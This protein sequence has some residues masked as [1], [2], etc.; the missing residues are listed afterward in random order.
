MFLNCHSY[1][2]LRYGTLSIEKLVE[3]AKAC[4]IGT[5]ALTDINNSTGI[6]DFVKSC[7]E[8]G[9]K[10]VAGIE[11]RNGDELLYIGLAKNNAGFRELNDF[12]SHHT[13]RNLPLPELAP[14]FGN[15]V[16]IYP[17][18]NSEIAKWRNGEIK[19]AKREKRSSEN[20]STRQFTSSPVHQFFG[21]SPSMLR[22]LATINNASLLENAVILF[23]VTH[24]DE[25]EYDLHC[26][27]RAV[28]HNI[29]LSRLRPEQVAGP[30]E[31]MV[32][33]EKVKEIYK[34]YPQLIKNT[35]KLLGECSIGF[36]FSSC[37][38]KKTFTG[39]PY[40][41]RILLEKLAYDGLEYRYGKSDR[42][43][44]KR[45]RHELGIIDKMGFSSY[46]LITWD[47]IR[48]SMS[49]G[50]YHVGRGSGANS[51][52]AYCLRI[53]DVDPIE[54]DLYFE[55]FINPK[56][57][58]PPDFDIDYSWKERDEVLD[59][60]FK[61]YGH[62]HTALLGAMSTFKGN[63]IYRELGKVHGLPKGEMDDFLKYPE[64]ENHRNGIIKKISD[65]GA[66]LVDFPNIRSIHAGGV[67]ISDEPI[68]CYTALDM[69]P[70]GFPTTQWD[71]YV[72]E[73]IGFEKL[74]ILSQ[75]GIGHIRETAE[76][77]LKNRSE[78]VD[79]HRVQ[80]FK[81][82]EN[83][84][85][86]LRTGETIGCFY[87]ESPAMRGLLK[88]LRCDNY[89]S[90]VAASSIIRPGVA[91]S[92][93][94]REYI[95]RFH[96]P[97][98]FKYL[99]PIMEEQLKETYGVM[100]YQEDV[101]KICHH[102]AGLDLA[103]SDVLRRAMSGKFRSKKE[104]ERIVNKFFENCKSY[105]YPDEVTKEVW[106]QI[107]SFAGY[108]FSK[109][110]SASYAVES[111]QSLFLKSHYPLEFM[112]GVINNFGGFY[113]SWVY[114]NEARNC[115]AVL[116]LPCVNRGDYKTSISGKDVFVGFIHVANLENP[117]GKM[118][119]AERKAHG[120]Y[121]S[122]DDFVLRTHITLEQ[123]IILI[124]IG[125]FRFTGKT[126]A[127]LLWEAH[128]L[129]GKNAELSKSAFRPPTSD[130]AHHP[131]PIENSIVNRKSEIVNSPVNPVLFYTPPKEYTLPSL[132]QSSVEDVYDEVELLGFPV[133]H[134]YFDL[135][136]TSFRGEIMA[137]AMMDRM[138]K[139][140]RMLGQ[141]VTI[142]YVRTVKKEWMH[143]GTFTD[144]TGHFF[145]TVHFPDS[146]RKYPF[147]GDG[148]YLVL[149]KIVE[150]FGFPS[151]E[152]HKMAKMPMRKDPRAG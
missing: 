106:R 61:R 127:Q 59:Y 126:K 1:Y 105:G 71:M 38:N 40:D 97:G 26:N 149:G 108:S 151:L 138:G 86:L 17:L 56:R 128:L 82:D 31:K 110:H 67:L 140:V 66:M 136:E 3:T 73:E 47:I 88:K 15:V 14:E 68:T 134:T 27:L 131:S 102:F 103:D 45:I 100:V 7:K 75:R 22:T 91:R 10:P 112:V 129:L 90:L 78:A 12:L 74:D 13:I 85:Q 146:V 87:V 109:A 53:T 62:K 120:V 58:S 5:L 121:L 150:E 147:R 64:N 37:K 6:M 29:L 80:E 83:V 72:A 33:E 2:S 89:R 48:Y 99:H 139:N 23:P 50:F 24:T 44:I 54:L 76:I 4:G 144:I 122:L 30:G 145:D 8:N 36:D 135:L 104:L 77:I 28:D 92:G 137:K 41:D 20:S 143:F 95:L 35:E 49:R 107:E 39:N 142:K 34:D 57:T 96:R 9:I 115:G 111:Y 79:V 84:K 63:S 16:T 101:L 65:L 70:K 19:K 21:V 98:G 25:K 55:R 117:V 93:M 119:G 116:H 124:R 125:A 18:Q 69:P 51:I 52:V 114:F 60:I 123:L 42:E 43:A 130:I 46:F 141:L 133:K 81:K 94:M 148:I 152:V 132:E 32:T 118:I 113:S 11:F